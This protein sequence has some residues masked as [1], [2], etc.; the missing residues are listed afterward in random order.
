MKIHKPEDVQ[1]GTI[2]NHPEY[3]G[4][5][6]MGV[7]MR[8]LFTIDEFVKK[9]LMVYESPDGK[10]IGMLMQEGE[11]ARQGMWELGFRTEDDEDSYYIIHT[12]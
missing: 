6:F 7:G 9:H 1:V 3:M 10:G 2:Y 5:R 8:K 4:Y 12:R 11:D